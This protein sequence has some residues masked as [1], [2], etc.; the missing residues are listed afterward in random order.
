MTYYSM[1]KTDE[2]TRTGFQYPSTAPYLSND[3]DII[4][5]SPQ[6]PEIQPF[7]KDHFFAILVKTQI[8]IN[9]TLTKCL[10]MP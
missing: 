1:M 2:I 8:Y 10:I 6:T 5:I 7:P 3:F 9:G 4:Q